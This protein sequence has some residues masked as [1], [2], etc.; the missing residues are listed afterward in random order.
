[1]NKLLLI[2]DMQEG[3]RAIESEAI[4]SNVLKLKKS[5]KGKIVLTKFINNKDSLFEKQLG[6]DKFQNTKERQLFLELQSTDNTEIEHSAYIIL[7]EKLKDFIFNNKIKQVY[8]CGVYTDVCVIKTAMDLFDSNLETFVIKDAC[9]SL[10]G[11]ANNDLIIDSLK[12]I[13]GEK[14]II[15]TKDICN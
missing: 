2:I 6:C 5:F 10:H 1:M 12:H 14:H 15:L 7:N 4:L 13:I 11:Q 8:L 3:F 9:N